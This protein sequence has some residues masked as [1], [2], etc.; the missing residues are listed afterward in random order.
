[1]AVIRKRGKTWQAMVRLKGH[2][3][4]SSTHPTKRHAEEWARA[5]E[6]AIQAGKRG[7]WPVKTVDQAL[8]R[9]ADEVSSQKRS[10]DYELKR[11]EAF[12]RD[13]PAI[14]AKVIST[15]TPDDIAKWRNARLKKVTP[16]TVQ[17]DA[18]LFRHV[19]TIAGKEWGWCSLES[20]WAR[21]TLPGNNAARDVVWNWRQVRAV[22]RRAGHVTGLPPQTAL[23]QVAA[24]FLLSLQTCMRQGEIHGL[25]TRA[26]DLKAR[27]IRLETHKTLEKAGVRHV[28]VP[29]RALPLLELLCKHASDGKL[30]TVAR[31]SV[32]TLF[33]RIRT[34]AG[35]QGLTFHDARATAAT[36]L[37]RRVDPLT[38][39]RIMG[40]RDLK[41]LMDTY[42][43][44]SAAQIAARL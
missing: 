15:V 40:H 25:E 18:N 2:P 13:F 6:G 32:D 4:I 20:P 10:G 41:Q 9:Y 28:P 3:C 8:T 30:F 24:M 21:V 31:A 35:V 27:V 34:D 14:A 29:R 1:M 16:G 17:R 43:R 26:I 11:I 12:R 22:M 19:W 44:E 37:A 5:E 39:A 7:A 38:L 33:R 23:A 42:Y 36:L